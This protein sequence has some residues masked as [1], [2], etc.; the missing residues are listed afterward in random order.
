MNQKQ[1]LQLLNNH[2]LDDYERERLQQLLHYM[3]SE[4]VKNTEETVNGSRTT[5]KTAKNSY[6]RPKSK[7]RTQHR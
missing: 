6:K 2:T 4:G 3:T 7:T 1:I 5:S